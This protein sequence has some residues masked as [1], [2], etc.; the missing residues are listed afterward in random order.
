MQSGIIDSLQFSFDKSAIKDLDTKLVFFYTHTDYIVRPSWSHWLYVK[1]KILCEMEN[2]WNITVPWN[3]VSGRFHSAY[4]E[5]FD[6]LCYM[7]SFNVH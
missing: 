5:L 6:I 3:C 4:L 2:S 7:Q 1:C